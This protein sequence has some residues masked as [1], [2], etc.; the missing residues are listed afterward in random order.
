[1]FGGASDRILFIESE[2][3]LICPFPPLENFVRE[4]L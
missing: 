3:V 2:S 4:R 1:M